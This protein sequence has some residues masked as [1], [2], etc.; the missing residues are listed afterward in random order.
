MYGAKSNFYAILSFMDKGKNIAGTTK[1]IIV[2][3]HDD[4]DGFTGAWAA[5]KKLKDKA[6]YMELGYDTKNYDFLFRL[7]DKDIYMVDCSLNMREM[8]RLASKNKVILIDH[9]FSSKE[10][11]D[12][13]PGSVF[14]DKHSGASLSWK[15]FHGENKAPLIVNYVQ[16][17]D[18]WK[19]KL[20]RTRELMAVLNLYSFNFKVWDKAA[21]M[22]QDKN[23]RK[24]L[25]KKGQAIVDYQKSLIG[26]L[27]NKGQEVIFE[28]CDAIAVN[29]PILSSEIGNHIYT[30][31]GKIGIVWSYKGKDR[32]KI[33]VSLR[34]DGKI[35]LS[36]LAKKYGGGGH[37]AAAGFAIEG[38]INF[39][40]KPKK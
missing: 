3:Y 40:W 36:E 7:Q 22:F 17:Y 1:K 4:L 18:L 33:H 10:K 21:K 30:K 12:L 26:E 32:P 39:P 29:S 38:D 24:E 19:F 13:L 6:E 2:I 23:K 11:A 8:L 20:P 5:W 16:D 37:K 9:H 15:Y 34:G 35:N 25:V 27:S 14:D 28:G 31:T